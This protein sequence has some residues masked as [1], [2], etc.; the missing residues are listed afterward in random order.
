[1]KRPKNSS[2]CISWGLLMRQSLKGLQPPASQSKSQGRK[3]GRRLGLRGRLVLVASKTAPNMR[4]AHLHPRIQAPQS[5]Q[6]PVKQRVR[7]RPRQLPLGSLSTISSTGSGLLL[8]F[9]F[10]IY[11]FCDLNLKEEGRRTRRDVD[12]REMSRTH[13][14]KNT[15]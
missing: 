4:M 10:G 6:G 1:M 2:K 9:C 15:T 12:A 3:M 7:K 5:C 13:F 14:D 11:C 8:D